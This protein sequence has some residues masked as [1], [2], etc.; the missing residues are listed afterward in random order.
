MPC[1]NAFRSLLYLIAA[2]LSI[3]IASGQQTNTPAAGQ[4]RIAGTV[5][6]RS[7][8]HPLARARLTINNN[9]NNEEVFSALTSEDGKFAF[10]GLHAG[11][12]ALQGGRRGYLSSFYEQHEQFSTAIV[13][14]AGVDT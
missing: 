11:K 5:V 13:T 9:K 1:W 4:Y 6:S 2:L 10:T 14:G 7:D 12:Y 3:Y 8:G